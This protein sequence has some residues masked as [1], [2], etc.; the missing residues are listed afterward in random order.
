MNSDYQLITENPSYWELK[1]GLLHYYSGTGKTYLASDIILTRYGKRYSDENFILRSSD[2]KLA[3]AIFH[4]TEMFSCYFIHPRYDGTWFNKGG[5]CWKLMNGSK[6]FGV[7]G[8]Y[9]DCIIFQNPINKHHMIAMLTFDGMVNMIDMC[10]D[11]KIRSEH[12]FI[13][14]CISMELLNENYFVLRRT[15]YIYQSS[16]NEYYELFNIKQL[17]TAPNYEPVTINKDVKNSVIFDK[18]NDSIIINNIRY[19]YQ[20]LEL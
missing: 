7:I 15:N 3:C 10:T 16:D 13:H 17:L 12:N 2:D 9:C 4:K 20:Q 14:T 5:I 1:N 19:T 6:I 11:K 8:N 18:I